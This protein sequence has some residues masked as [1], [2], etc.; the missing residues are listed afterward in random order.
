M[1]ISTSCCIDDFLF[2]DLSSDTQSNVFSNGCVKKHRLL[3]DKTD[4]GTQVGQIVVM[5]GFTVD[6][7]VTQIRVIESFNKVDNRGFSAPCWP[8]ESNGLAGSDNTIQVLVYFHF[9][10]SW[11]SKRDISEFNMTFN[12]KFLRVLCWFLHFRNPV[13]NLEHAVRC[14]KTFFNIWIGSSNLSETHSTNQDTK[15]CT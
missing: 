1:C 13:D 14:N 12:S 2:S 4:L 5:D 15:N 9:F 3:A 11:I 7:N 6:Q 10:T 8:T